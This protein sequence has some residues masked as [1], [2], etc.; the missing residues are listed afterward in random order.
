MNYVTGWLTFISIVCVQRLICSSNTGGMYQL[1]APL[2]YQAFSGDLEIEYKLLTNVS[3]PHAFVR[4]LCIND[5]KPLEV[6]TLALPL[7]VNDGRLL[8]M[9]GILEVA[10]RY[11]ARLYTHEGGTILTEAKFDVSWPS[12]HLTLPDKY[13]ALTTGV[14]MRISSSVSCKSLL[15]R[16]KMV[17]AIYHVRGDITDQLPLGSSNL[18]TNTTMIDFTSQVEHEFPCNFFDVDGSYQAVLKST[19]KLGTEI[20]RSN[21]M[22]AV[23]SDHYNINIRTDSVFPCPN[24]LNILYTRPSCPSK[25]KIRIFMLKKEVKGSLASPL[26]RKYVFERRISPDMTMLRLSCNLFNTTSAGYCFMYVSVSKIGSVQEQKQVCLSAHPNSDGKWSSW[27]EWGKCSPSCGAGKRSRYRLCNTPAPANGG[28]FCSGEAFQWQSCYNMCTDKIPDTPLKVMSFDSMCTCGCQVKAES[29]GITASGRCPGKAVWLIRTSSSHRIRFVFKYIDLLVDKQ[30]VTIRNGDNDNSDL[31]YRSS[32]GDFKREIYSS[33]N[34]LLV[35]LF[36]S[37]NETLHMLNVTLPVYFHGFMATFD[38]EVVSPSSSSI[39]RREMVSILDSSATTVGIAL[40]ILIVIIAVV[41][42]AFHKTFQKRRHKYAMAGTDSP[43]RSL[44]DHSCH[45][46]NDAIEDHEIQVRLADETKRKQLTPTNGVS[47]KSSVTS[48]CS[49]GL[50]RFR[51]KADSD[52]IQ[53]PSN[54]GYTPLVSPIG[55]SDTPEVHSTDRK[56]FQGSPSLRK[57]APRSPKVHPS[58]KLRHVTINSQ[59]DSPVSTKQELLTKK[60]YEPSDNINDKITPTNTDQKTPTVDLA[61]NRFIAKRN[62]DNVPKNSD[63]SLATI[64]NGEVIEKPLKKETSFIQTVPKVPRP[65]SLSESFSLDT[66]NKPANGG[67]LMACERDRLLPKPDGQSPKTYREEQALLVSP[68]SSKPSKT[69]SKQSS[70]TSP[71]HSVQ[72]PSEIALDGLELEYDDFIEDDPL[73]YFDYDE[74]QR[75]KWHG[76]EKIGKPI[77]EEDD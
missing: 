36:T 42:V 2:L 3:L 5:P 69:S 34:T 55:A 18:I 17:L 67:S 22:A 72:T 66:I 77:N 73:S 16:E 43:V 27:S 57:C 74:M 60:R 70:M 23:W 52:I 45:D 61:L 68:S 37:T 47:R 1:M 19:Y 12:I 9:C 28:R 14:K 51:S 13:V 39:I 75:L 31:L 48:V 46:S 29:G 38:S 63:I 24:L 15:N 65:T 71:S 10:G 76:G 58:P 6:T 25:D 44:H 62:T 21:I 8:V 54:K 64:Q 32:E 56:F 35:E 53:K 59:P 50:K 30:V 7:G 33:G 41:F 26:Q 40:C 20:T 4:L 49:N 11:V